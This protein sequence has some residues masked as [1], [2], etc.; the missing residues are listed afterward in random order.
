[1]A[2]LRK[3]NRFGSKSKS[4]MAFRRPVT[5]RFTLVPSKIVVFFRHGMPKSNVS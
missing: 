3:E 2:K 5:K 4:N 1:L